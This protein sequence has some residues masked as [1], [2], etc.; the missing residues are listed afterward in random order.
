MQHYA[1]QANDP[2][3]LHDA[4]AVRERADYRAG[5][6]LLDMD[7]HKG[8]REESTGNAVL[9][10]KNAMP[11]LWDFGISKIQSSRW[12][13]KAALSEDE[14]ELHLQRAKDRALKSLD[15]RALNR[16]LP[17]AASVGAKQRDKAA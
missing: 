4:T 8:G 13:K 9:P 5:Q 3:L 2:Q 1:T 16:T 7:L 6:L 10:V 11:K 17:R 12:Q 14:F 15:T